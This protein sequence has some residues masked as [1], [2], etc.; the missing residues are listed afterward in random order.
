MWSIA[1]IVSFVNEKN[2]R[3]SFLGDVSVE[4]EMYFAFHEFLWVIESIFDII[5]VVIAT[6]QSPTRV[7]TS[8]FQILFQ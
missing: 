5:W 6:C 2:G 1:A 7:Y 8:T 4:K 3:E